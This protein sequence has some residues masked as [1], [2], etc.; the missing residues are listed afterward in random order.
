MKQ[1][2]QLT[3]L[4]ALV[5]VIQSCAS[6]YVGGFA[7]E[8]RWFNHAIP[9]FMQQE[10]FDLEY[11]NCR[12]T[13]REGRGMPK[14]TFSKDHARTFSGNA[15][16]RENGQNTVVYY[17]GTIT[18]QPSFSKGFEVGYGIGNAIYELE[19]V[20]KAEV[21]C[22]EKLGWVPIQEKSYLPYYMNETIPFNRAF[23]DLVRS[24]YTLPMKSVNSIILFNKA[25]SKS[26]TNDTPAKIE[27]AVLKMSENTASPVKCETFVKRDM[28]YL[29]QCNDGTSD[30]GEH[31]PQTSALGNY[32][33]Q[34]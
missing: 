6:S 10:A 30:N 24:G 7:G 8:R 13:A 34:L 32:L 2:V 31:L 26:R 4:F 9:Y 21:E 20:A 5:L 17:Q 27:Y 29:T 33:N 1:L 16:I 15:T 18:E 11:R 25:M 23:M 3:F 28:S 19:A 14:I 22:L 12:I